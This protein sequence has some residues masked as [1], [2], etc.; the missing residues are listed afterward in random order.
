MKIGMDYG[1]SNP[2]NKI[3]LF[4]SNEVV[5][6]IL[7]SDQQQITCEVNHDNC[8][9]SFL[10]TYVYAK[11]RDQLR[12]PLWDSMLKWSATV[13]PW[14]ILGD[15]NVITSAQE[16]LGGREY[17]IRKSLEFINIID[18]CGLIDMG[19][20]GQPYTW[21]NH[22]NNGDMI[23][24]RLDRGMVNDKWLDIM[25]HTNV[26]HLPSVGSD[27]S[28][29]LLDM[30]DHK[31]TVIKYFKFLNYWTENDTF[32]HTVENCWNKKVTGN[33]MWILHTKLKRL[34]K[35]LREWSKKEY[36][37]VFEKVKFYEES[38]KTAEGNYI[39]DSSRDNREQL[40][41]LN[42]Q[43][44]KY[45]KIE[46]AILQ[47]KT[48]LHWLKEGDANSKYFHAVIRGKRK[49]MVIHKLLNDNGS[50]IQGDEVIARE[51]CNYYQNIFT[52]KS[53][54]INEDQ[55]QCIPKMVTME[56]NHDLERMPNI[57][58]LRNI[59]MNM[60]PHSAP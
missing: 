4:W 36:G 11:C 19:Y 10:M 34:T 20:N 30:I 14:C 55:L 29:L 37:D 58:E 6:K 35:T 57:D 60:N 48:H 1:H 50:C 28:P 15:F 23:W 42:A 56:Q 59:V 9:E 17:N 3:W 46:H 47:Q 43:Y 18:S 22:R 38:V 53:V 26:T 39:R 41:A 40:Y 25:P 8:S 24:K 7:D 5:C 13:H 12:K 52:G 31:D 21:C 54:K 49:K 44:I 33:P 2:N 45:L 32:L 16:K 51:A 27:H